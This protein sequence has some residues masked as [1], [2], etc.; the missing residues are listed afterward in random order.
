[1]TKVDL[2]VRN[3]LVVLDDRMF[4][5][6]VAAAGGVVVAIGE[7]EALPDAVETIDAGGDYVIPGVIDTHV[8]FREPG[9][10]RHEDFGTGS[11][12]AVMGGVTTVFEMP[13]TIPPTSTGALV[14]EKRSVVMPKSYV[15]FGL[16]GIVGQENLDE[17]EGMAEAGVIGYKL[18]L[19]QAIEGISPCDDGALLEAFERIAATGL[20]AAVHAENPHI[21][22]RRA[23][24]LRSAGR[25]D[26]V[27]NLEARPSISEY[28][29]VDRC[30]SFARSAGT[31]LHVCHV[32]SMESLEAIRTG[33]RTGVDVTAETGPQWLWFTGEDTKRKGTV[34][35]FSPPFRSSNDRDALWEGLRDGTIDNIATDHAP[36]LPEEKIAESVWDVKSGFIGVETQLPLLFTAVLEGRLDASRYVAL[37]SRDPARAYGVWPRKGSLLPGSDADIT[38]VRPG[39]PWEIRHENL[40]S[41]ARVTPFEGASVSCR[42]RCTVLR[43]NV[44]MRDGEI[45]GRPTGR[46]V[47]IMERSGEQVAPEGSGR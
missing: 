9:L 31:K 16:F 23:E 37:T 30:I 1:M 25:H 45:V 36:R 40:H 32:T 44:V 24:A 43:G 19:H 15:D 41:R 46:D 35:M 3:G 28:D 39:D 7:D 20:R 26:A 29:M 4:Q 12:A 13:N 42:V 47:R 11:T 27:A 18:Y 2:V 5:G 14:T 6:G 8:H 38:I 17:I 22:P 33:K 34:L 21:Y 10:P